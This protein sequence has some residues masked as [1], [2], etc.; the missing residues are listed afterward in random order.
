ME[1]KEGYKLTEVGVIPEKWEISKLQ[2]Y[3][4]ITSG[5]SPSKFIFKKSGVPYYKV[6]Q[7]NNTN[8]Y[9]NNHTPY[10]INMKQKVVHNSVI[11]PKRG[12]AIFLN[13]IR[14]LKEDAFFD[15]NLMA[16]TIHTNEL[17]AEYLFYILNFKGLDQ[18]ADTTS[19]PQINNKHINPFIIPIPPKPEQQAIAQ[20]LSDT[21][22]LID[23]LEKL[24]EKKCHIKQ[25]AMQELLTGKRRLP[26][27]EVKQGYK[28]MELGEI[29]EDWETSKLQNHVEITSGDSPSKFTF[30]ENGV[31]YYKVEQLNNA[32]KYLSKETP[33]FIDTKN[34]VL[35]N[36]VIF[37]K[38]GAAIFLNKIRL[39][40]DD[41]FFDT[42]LMALTIHTD[43]LLTEYL[44]YIL[45]FNGLD[46]IADTTSVPQINNKHINPFVIPMPPKSEQQAI[47]AILS[48]MDSEIEAIENKLQKTK[49]IK[50]GM[51]EKL[52]S[53][54]I[55]LVNGEK[56]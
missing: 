12:A 56:Q 52:L 20:A 7:L 8:K 48:D 44:F 38:R 31:P 4:T 3:I 9:L 39:L 30:K 25:G 49:A 53:G 41:A 34:T 32:N 6:E 11:F 46:Q 1:V 51:M 33:Y 43:E 40:A 50:G 36:S 35:K 26:G 29:P 47:A 42:N 15:T 54:K 28:Q 55:R 37:P 2:D 22:A 21:D 27:F 16:L 10:F 5:D 14:L 45:D 18:I 17:L 23:A 24:I 13:K 19:V